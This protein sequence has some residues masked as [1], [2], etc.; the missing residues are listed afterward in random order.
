MGET[1]GKLGRHKEA[2]I[3][4]RQALKLRQE[5]FGDKHLDMA[6]SLNNLRITLVRLGRHEEALACQQEAMALKEV[7]SKRSSTL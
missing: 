4:Q 5:I 3:Y 7:F 1:L 6:I 2:L